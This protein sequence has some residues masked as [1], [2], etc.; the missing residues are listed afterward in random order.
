MKRMPRN[1]TQAQ[2]LGP[3]RSAIACAKVSLRLNELRSTA[4]ALLAHTGASMCLVVTPPQ[5]RCGA[6]QWNEGGHNMP[7]LQ[8]CTLPT[9]RFFSEGQS[10][11]CRGSAKVQETVQLSRAQGL[12]SR[13]RKG[14]GVM[15][16][17]EETFGKDAR[18]RWCPSWRQQSYRCARSAICED[19]REEP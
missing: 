12:S 10:R 13:S 11:R 16:T 8:R 15:K 14:T 9:P 3:I 6:D 2:P 4:S 7:S 5:S 19:S 1:A 17:R 18:K